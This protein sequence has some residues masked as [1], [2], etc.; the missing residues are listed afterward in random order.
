MLD[1]L[2]FAEFCWIVTK[3]DIIVVFWV[4][5]KKNLM[6]LFTRD[7]LHLRVFHV[8]NLHLRVFL[9][10]FTVVGTVQF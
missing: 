8:L 3:K 6:S 7:N 10:T 4:D 1:T 5:G 9:C 2:K